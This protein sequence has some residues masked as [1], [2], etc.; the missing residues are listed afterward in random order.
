MYEFH[1]NEGGLNSTISYLPKT[2]PAA[3]VFFGDGCTH[4]GFFPLTSRPHGSVGLSYNGSTRPFGIY[5]SKNI[6]ITLYSKSGTLKQIS[7]L[8]LAP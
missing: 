6:F 2:S 5:N 7:E 4:R 8:Q 1:A 3:R